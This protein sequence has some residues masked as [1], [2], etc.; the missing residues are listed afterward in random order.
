[1]KIKISLTMNPRN[2][3]YITKSQTAGTVAKHVC[4]H[5]VKCILST[6]A[7]HTIYDTLGKLAVKISYEMQPF[8]WPH[9]TNLLRY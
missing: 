3:G 2:D 1:M 7:I 4:L 5:C 8:D 6:Q 9:D